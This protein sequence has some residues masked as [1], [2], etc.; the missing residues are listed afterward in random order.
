MG[1]FFLVKYC[2]YM[3][4]QEEYKLET[5]GTVT[6]LLNNKDGS[7]RYLTHHGV[8]IVRSIYVAVR[9]RYYYKF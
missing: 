2:Y 7:I 4:K 1:Y 3:Y 9:D 8:E 5:F 6:F